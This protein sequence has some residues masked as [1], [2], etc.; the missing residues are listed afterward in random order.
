MSATYPSEDLSFI[1]SQCLL[2]CF[3]PV[4]SGNLAMVLLILLR[5]F[6]NSSSQNRLNWGPS[7]ALFSWWSAL[8]LAFRISQTSCAVFFEVLKGLEGP[9]DCE[10]NGGDWFPW[11]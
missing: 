4:V 9:K 1:F 10:A 3:L 11:D 7:F 2:E 8:G 6:Q 5:A